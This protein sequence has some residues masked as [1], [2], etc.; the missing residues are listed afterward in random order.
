[1]KFIVHIS[2]KKN[3]FLGKPLTLWTGKLIQKK[4]SVAEGKIASKVNFT[5]T[6]QHLEY[7]NGFY[8]ADKLHK[9]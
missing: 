3:L 1:M 7:F 2:K 8:T 9:I 6:E 4:L 5:A